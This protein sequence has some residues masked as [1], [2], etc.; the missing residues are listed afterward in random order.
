MSCSQDPRDKCE[1]QRGSGVVEHSHVSNCAGLEINEWP[2]AQ[3]P[4]YLDKDIL[5]RGIALTKMSP[6]KYWVPGFKLDREALR[7]LAAC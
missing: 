3:V 7:G 6:K 5:I 1:K 4:V 2:N